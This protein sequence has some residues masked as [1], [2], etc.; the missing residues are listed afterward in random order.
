[1]LATWLRVHELDVRPLHTDEAVGAAKFGRLLEKGE[2]QYDPFEYHGPTLSYLTLIPVWVSGQ[3]TYAE[4]SIETLRSL[5]VFFGL[6]LVLLPVLLFFGLDWR[7]TLVAT[8]VVAISPVMV[9]YSRYYIH[10]YILV[11]FTFLSFFSYFKL[12]KSGNLLWSVLL[13]LSVGMMIA[14]KE[15][16][17]I[18]L[19]GL[20]IAI[21]IGGDQKNLLHFVISKRFLVAFGAMLVVVITFFSSFY[22]HFQGLTDM[23]VT[24]GTYLDRAGTEDLHRHPWYYYLELLGGNPGPGITWTEAPILLL[25]AL[26]VYFLLT[27]PKEDPLVMKI[28]IFGIFSL[29]QLAIYSA[30]PYKTPWNLLSLY[31]GIIFLAGYGIINLLKIMESKVLKVGVSALF[32]LISIQ[33]TGQTF[34]EYRHPADP[35]NPWVYGHTAG[36]FHQVVHT[37]DSMA[38]DGST[39]IEVIFPGND[40]WPF[41]WY[42]RNYENVAYRDRVDFEA[43]GGEMILIAP[44]LEEDLVEKL[45]ERPAAGEQYLYLYLFDSIQSLRP[46]VYFNGY[47]RQDLWEKNQNIIIKND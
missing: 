44:S 46:N 10:E 12:E 41:P 27:A 36:D 19:A 11:F 9:F 35:S 38:M 1:M 5:P 30:L 39:Y 23:L 40:Y 17:I 31:V 7:Y 43:P 24:Y 26:G 15:T 33:L 3:S 25:A 34:S 4:L 8:F 37:I 20:V 22:T 6:M 32:G 45:Y 47:L 42:L 21:L 18:S 2:Y 13:G 28:R 16:W 29:F 14:T